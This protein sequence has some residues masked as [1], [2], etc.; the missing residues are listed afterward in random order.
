MTLS[1]ENMILLISA[2]VAPIAIGMWRFSVF[3]SKLEH[4]VVMLESSV[5]GLRQVIQDSEANIRRE[6]DAKIELHQLKHNTVHAEE[7]HMLI[8]KI[9]EARV[10]NIDYVDEAI[11]KHISTAH[12]K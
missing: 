5:K 3:M 10:D 9:N 4:T 11:D 8:D 2:V 7:R 1:F 12:R 6:V